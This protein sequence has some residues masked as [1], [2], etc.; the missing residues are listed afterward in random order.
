MLES[1]VSHNQ[2]QADP[3]AEHTHDCLFGRRERDTVRAGFAIPRRL[4][5]EQPCWLLGGGWF[6][7]LPFRVVAIRQVLNTGDANRTRQHLSF[8]ARARARR[9]ASL[10][11][12]A[13]TPLC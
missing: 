10:A 1:P 13:V 9:A 4:Q 3:A 6:L 8:H 11:C 7:H 5:Q 2:I 12:A